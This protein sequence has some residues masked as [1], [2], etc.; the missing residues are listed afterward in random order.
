MILDGKVPR[1]LEQ[2]RAA[3]EMPERHSNSRNLDVDQ[4]KTCKCRSCPFC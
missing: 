3:T 4:G 1:R 2:P